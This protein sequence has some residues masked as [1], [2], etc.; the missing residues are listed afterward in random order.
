SRVEHLARPG[1]LPAFE[2]RNPI[3]IDIRKHVGIPL[4]CLVCLRCSRR[5]RL[6]RPA[7]ESRSVTRRPPALAGA[8]H[9]PGC[10]QPALLRAGA[11]PRARVIEGGQLATQLSRDSFRREPEADAPAVSSEPGE[12]QEPR[13]GRGSARS[14]S[15]SSAAAGLPRRSRVLRPASTSLIVLV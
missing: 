11:L 2:W 5:R 9:D 1:W 7:V 8:Y 15:G 6:C 10:G 14:S 3:G 4:E 12:L 13:H